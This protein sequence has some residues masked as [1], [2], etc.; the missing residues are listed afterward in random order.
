MEVMLH[1]D[2]GVYL[3]VLRWRSMRSTLDVLSLRGLKTYEGHAD[4]FVALN[5]GSPCNHLAVS[6]RMIA[7]L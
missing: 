4:V 5:T 6:R 1:C 7:E 3:I 2:G